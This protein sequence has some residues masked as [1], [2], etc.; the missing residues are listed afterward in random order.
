M[1]DIQ[2]IG[3]EAAVWSIKD[4]SVSLRQEI[5][6]AARQQGCTVA[7]W[8]HGH[9]QRF[10]VGEARFAPVKLT[11]LNPGSP[12]D[13][14]GAV[15]ELATLI[16]AAARFAEVRDKLPTGVATALGRRLKAAAASGA[17]RTRRHGASGG[18][19]HPKPEAGE[20]AHHRRGA[21]SMMARCWSARIADLRMEGGGPIS[22][23]RTKATDEGVHDLRAKLI[24]LFLSRRRTWKGL[25]AMGTRSGRHRP[26]RA[27]A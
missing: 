13:L 10:G 14:A 24:G 11:P 12:G 20:A 17:D 2:R 15:A 23:L 8:L 21:V 22:A 18:C 25:A 1:D 6:R 4:F 19:H 16:D 27:G 26:R 5:I 7:E 9:F 3:T